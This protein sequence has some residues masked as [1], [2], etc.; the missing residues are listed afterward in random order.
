MVHAVDDEA[1]AQVLPGLVAGPLPAG[2]D[3]DRHRVGRLALN[4]LDAPPQL[5]RGPQRVDELEVVV[6]Q[7]R[8]EE[9]AHRVERAALQRR[10]VGSG[11]ALGHEPRDAH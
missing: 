10:D 11:A 6:G 3:E 1:D 7:Q 9:G 8:R 2:L 5:L 4:A